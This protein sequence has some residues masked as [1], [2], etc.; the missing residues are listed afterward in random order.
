MTN[1]D[2][3]VSAGFPQPNFIEVPKVF[4]DEILPSLTSLEEVREYLDLFRRA[5]DFRDPLRWEGIAK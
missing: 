2:N 3:S 1:Q 5:S 4:L